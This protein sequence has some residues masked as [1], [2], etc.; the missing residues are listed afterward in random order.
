MTSRKLKNNNFD[1]LQ[2]KKNSFV[3]SLNK[4]T[5]GD[6]PGGPVAKTALPLLGVGV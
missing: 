4:G 5:L 6:F 2:V 1:I 3:H